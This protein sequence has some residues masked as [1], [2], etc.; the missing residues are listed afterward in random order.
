MFLCQGIDHSCAQFTVT[1]TG[2]WKDHP[3][4]MPQ[5]EWWEWYTM[6][7][8]NPYYKGLA[9]KRW[10]DMYAIVPDHPMFDEVN[11]NKVDSLPT[12]ASMTDR[13]GVHAGLAGGPY[14][15]EAYWA[16]R[17]SSAPN[18]PCDI[19]HKTVYAKQEY[20]VVTR[21]FAEYNRF[22]ILNGLPNPPGNPPFKSK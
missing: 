14:E 2:E 8:G 18:C 17:V 3:G 15:Q 13:P 6:M 19:K 4:G 22:Y 10:H 1:V 11:P 5:V 16:I 7:A 20:K 9:T 21:N 12:K